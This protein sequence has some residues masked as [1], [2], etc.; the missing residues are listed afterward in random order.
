MSQ[1][2][3]FRGRNR[4]DATEDKTVTL[5]ET[6]ATKANPNPQNCVHARGLLRDPAIN[7][8]WVGPDVVM[9]GYVGDADNYYRFL[10]EPPPPT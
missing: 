10:Q 2:P 7:E 6:D 9:V 4:V 5:I 1:T 8:V 3:R